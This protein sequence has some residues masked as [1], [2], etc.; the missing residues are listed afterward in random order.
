MALILYIDT[1]LPTAH[2]GF[3]LNGVVLASATNSNQ[4]SHA[5]FIHSTVDS[6]CKQLNIALTNINAVAINTG[7]GSYTGIRVGLA[8]AKGYCYALNKP[9]IA[10]NTLTLL[11]EKV[12]AELDV[13]TKSNAFFVSP[14]V[15]ARRMEV[16]NALFDQ[17]K[18]TILAPQATILTNN[19][20]ANY[21]QK[22]PVFLVGCGAPKFHQITTH[23]NFVLLPYNIDNDT[24]AR[25]SIALF[26]KNAFSN[27]AYV[28]ANYVKDFVDN[29][30]AKN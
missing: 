26:L 3:A 15:D 29:P 8:A 16:F 17:E 13:N 4:K 9:I 12:F 18:N 27:I 10:L 11:T 24:L 30:N 22:A 6:L 20:L 14:M 23:S 7:P 21:A 19:F 1:C 2:V 25:T 28:S 5:T